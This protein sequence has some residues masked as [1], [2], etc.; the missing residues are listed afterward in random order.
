MNWNLLMVF[1]GL[2]L[3]SVGVLAVAVDLQF[4]VV[5]WVNRLLDN[6]FSQHGINANVGDKFYLSYSESLMKE[7]RTSADTAPA[8]GTYKVIVNTIT[9]A[10]CDWGASLGEKEFDLNSSLGELDFDVLS[11]T[12]FYVFTTAKSDGACSINLDLNFLE[13]V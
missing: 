5:D 2:T 8:N 9:E 1:F 13:A 11:G 3:F 7:L 10:G 4:D 12:K 6:N